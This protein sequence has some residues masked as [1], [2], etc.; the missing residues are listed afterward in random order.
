LHGK[1]L[2][3]EHRRSPPLRG[4]GFFTVSGRRTGLTNGDC[5]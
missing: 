5:R 3:N 2:V 1:Q 4:Y